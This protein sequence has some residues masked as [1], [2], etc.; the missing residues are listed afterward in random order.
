MPT[1]QWIQ[2]EETSK[3]TGGSISVIT[4]GLLMYL[5]LTKSPSKLGSYKWLMLYTSFFEFFYAFVNLFAGPFVHTY[6]SAFIVFQDMNTFY[7]SHHVAQFLVCLY[8]SCFGFSMAIFGGHFIYRY[9]AIDSQFY[10]KYLSGFKQSLLYIL[11][12]CYGIL[13]GVICWIYYGE[14]PDRTNYL[15]ETLLSNYRLKI[16][17]CAYIS[18][19]FWVSDK[20]NYLFPDFDSFFG[21]G[22]MWIILGSSMISVIYFGTRCY[23][24]LTKK[25]EMI[26]NISDS[27]KSLQRQLFNALLIQSA[28]PLFLMYMPAAMV[29]VFPMLNT[30]LNLKYPFIGITIAIYPAIDPF[31][32]IIIIKSYRR[33]FYELLRC[34]TGRQKNKVAVNPNVP[35]HAYTLPMS[36]SNS[37]YVTN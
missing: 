35:S 16:E 26:E 36:A 11:P 21:I 8:C 32:T 9:G 37:I 22:V 12:F 30:E 27:I 33:G 34:L 31:P 18:A 15:R 25:L 1:V 24:W 3:I 13:W 23:R 14:T 7:F 5:I 6:G 29:F 10:Q 19:R 4:N 17:E 28:I 20:N 2:L